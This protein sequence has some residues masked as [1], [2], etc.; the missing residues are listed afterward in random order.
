MQLTPNIHLLQIDFEIPI[1]HDKKLA[2]FVN[3]III[4]GDKI[5]LIDTGVKGS[6][7]KIAEYLKS[8]G[9]DLSEIDQIIISHS[10]PDHIGSAAQL[11]VLTGCNILAHKAEQRW[12]EH[13]ETQNTERPVPGFF[14]LVDHSVIIDAFLENGDKI[15]IDNTLTLEIIHAPG[16]SAGSLNLLFC[17]KNILFTADSIPLKNDIPNYDNYNE[18]RNSLNNIKKLLPNCNYLLTSWTPAIDNREQMIQLFTDGKTYMDKL[19]EVV[20]KNYATA[21]PELENCKQTVEELGLPPFFAN[22]IVDKAFRS[23][24]MQ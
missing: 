20:L 7:T 2:R 15:I 19:N 12:I 1:A 16:H 14:G 10:H 21:L 13:I 8:I 22:P 9:R 5:M 24:K 18:L 6:E 23:H 4:L 3:V 11:K 17:E